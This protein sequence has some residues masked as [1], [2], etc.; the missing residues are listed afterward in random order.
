MLEQSDIESFIESTAVNVAC[1]LEQYVDNIEELYTWPFDAIKAEELLNVDFPD[2]S[3]YQQTLKLKDLLRKKIIESENFEDS[4]RFAKYFIE[5]WGGVNGNTDLRKVLKPYHSHQGKVID[6]ALFSNKLDKVST[7]SKY[8]SLICV[9]ASIYDSRVAYAINAINYMENNRDLFFPMPEGRSA[10]LRI[11]DID[12]FFVLDKFSKDE[13]FITD[14]D[15]EHKQISARL[16][17]KYYLPKSETYKL[18]LQLIEKVSNKLKLK[19]TEHFK[20]ELLLFSLAPN[21]IFK[22]LI[23]S[24]KD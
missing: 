13:V 21:E 19:P 14:E 9:N 6:T 10:R 12:S 16:K 4:F 20:I 24:L 23:S 3:P 1:F 2:T 8:L 11:I 22:S 7:W 18:Y 5:V 15:L 17:K